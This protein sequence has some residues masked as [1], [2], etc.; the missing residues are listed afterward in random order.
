MSRNPLKEEVKHHGN[1]LKRVGRP[2]TRG[3]PTV[4][5]MK[6]GKDI[7]KTNLQHWKKEEN[8]ATELYCTVK[9]SGA[10]KPDEEEVDNR[11]RG[12]HLY[13]RK[14]IRRKKNSY[15]GVKKLFLRKI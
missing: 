1:K 10:V 9:V 8:K 6:Y 3:T 15:K 4:R 14:R 5:G 12:G 11:G 7:K 2:A 13:Q